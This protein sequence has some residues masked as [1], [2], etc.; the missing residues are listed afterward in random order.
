M[1]VSFILCIVSIVSIVF[2]FLKKNR[3][4]TND[5]CLLDGTPKSLIL[6]NVRDVSHDTIRLRFELPDGYRLGLPIGKHIQ[7]RANGYTT[8]RK[9]PGRWNGNLDLEANLT[10]ISRKYTPVSN[11]TDNCVDLVV[12]VYGECDEFVDGGKMSQYL[13]GLAIGD[14]IEVNG[15]IGMHEYLGNGKFSTLGGK[16][17]SM[18]K[19]GMFAGGTGIT[20]MYQL[21]STILSDPN[22]HTHISM[23]Y[24]NKTEND[25]LMREELDELA[26][27][28]GDRFKLWYTVCNP[29]DNKPWMYSKGFVTADMIEEHILK[30]VTDYSRDLGIL[31]CGPPG[32]VQYA[33]KN[34]LKVLGV[35]ENILIF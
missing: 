5:N 4:I 25:I 16:V 15:P 26:K 33:C 1:L 32:F 12:K 22:D 23:I 7:V 8:I 28:H 3:M 35:H 13:K 18:S 21:I 24:A 34:N 30:D 2:Y 11:A 31:I 29:P 17:I 20:P 19:V 14:C 27:L 10:S 9:V 6:S